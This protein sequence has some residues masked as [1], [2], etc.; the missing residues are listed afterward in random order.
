M[1]FKS[2]LEAGKII[3][4]QLEPIYRNKKCAVVALS[5][6]AVV[7]GAEIAVRL[8]CVLTMLLTAPII[9]PHENDAIGAVSQD[10]NVIYNDLYST[11]ELEELKTEYRTYIEQ[12]RL[13]NIY[14]MNNLLGSGGLIRRDL[15]TGKN[16]I[17]VSDGLN[18]GFSLD[19]AVEFLK[20]INI[21]RLIVATPLASVPAVDRMHILTDEI[22][23][24]D[25]V[26]NYISTD[27]YY[28]A[29]DVPSHDVVINIIESV[30]AH[31]KESPS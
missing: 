15:L 4:D 31:W 1:Y 8:Q 18:S 16:V 2:R 12:Q 20:P 7:I 17:L 6:G 25:V 26:A 11:G 5:N 24:L 28:E 14:E 27:H 30:V 22:H 23:C 3:A 13:Q 19:A 10:G 9:L 21:K 29:K